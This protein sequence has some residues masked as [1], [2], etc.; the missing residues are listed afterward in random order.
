MTPDANEGRWPALPLAAWEETRATLHMC[1]QIVGKTTLPF[2]D[3]EQVRIF[4]I[5]LCM[6]R[7]FSASA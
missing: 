3:H 6:A 1:L 2:S 7:Y 5:G 4:L